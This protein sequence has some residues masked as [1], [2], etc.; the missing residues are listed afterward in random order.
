MTLRRSDGKAR[1]S[2]F[3]G[4]IGNATAKYASGNPLARLL[5]A[6]FLRAV[7]GALEALEPASVLDVGCG[8]GIVTERIAR[9]VP[10]SPVTGLDADVSLLRT[11]WQ[12]RTSPNLAFIAGS[13]Y[14]LP[15]DDSSF[16]LVCAFEVLEHLERPEVALAQIARVASTS[17]VLSVPREPIWRIVHLLAGRDVRT[18]GNTPGHLNH[19]SAR[20]FR[21]LAAGYGTVVDVRTPFPWTMVTLR[22]R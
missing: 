9:V 19:W 11:E 13:A 6:R 1:R 17:V 7:D 15:F 16:D 3:Q 14:D 10:G 5:V 22:A 12:A 4:P 18:L 8:E 21:E 20:G 2:D